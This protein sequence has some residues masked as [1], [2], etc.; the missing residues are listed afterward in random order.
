MTKHFLLPD[1]QV[2]PGVPLAHLEW[3]GHQQGRDIAYGQRADG[4]NMTAIISG[5]FY[6]HHEPYLNPQTNSHWHGVW[7]FHDVKD[8]AFDELPISI[9]YLRKKYG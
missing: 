7:M 3:A 8:G 6:Q 1:C 2:K 9:D 5:S 4:T